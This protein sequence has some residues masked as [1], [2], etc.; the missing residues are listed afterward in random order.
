M[1]KLFNRI[2]K[3]DL[4]DW[5]VIF[6]GVKGIPSHSEFLPLNSIRIFIN[7]ELENISIEDPIFELVIDLENND[8]SYFD[9]CLKLQK[10]C[11]LRNLDTNL[12]KR[13]WRFVALEEVLENLEID[14]LYGLINL[15]S[16]WATWEWPNDTPLSILNLS[17]KDYSFENYKFIINEHHQ[18]LQ[19]E[20]V[21]LKG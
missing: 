1:N 13:I 6:Q 16:F 3:H 7:K 11:E 4:I 10:I 17:A 18:W 15:S 5:A 20:L 9:A 21:H 19:S 8:L 14:P 12:A 2:L